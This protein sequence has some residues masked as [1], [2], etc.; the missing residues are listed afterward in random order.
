MAGDIQP[1]FP[2]LV[3]VR[4]LGKDFGACGLRLGLVAT[5]NQPVLGE[6]RRFLPIWNI[7]PLAEKFFRLCLKHRADYERARV[8]CIEETQSLARQLAAIPQLKVFET[9]SNFILFKILDE[10]FNSIQLRDHLLSQLGLYVRDCSR[11]LGLGDR[12]IR[13]GTNLPEENDRLVNG[14]KEFFAAM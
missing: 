3:I 5:A 14:I 13:I 2:N 9:W 7:N 6:I 4:S 10:R 8:Q 11:K 12:F 1:Q